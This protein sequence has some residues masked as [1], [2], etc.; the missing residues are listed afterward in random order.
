[1]Q[2]YL[3]VAISIVLFF[4]CSLP[5]ANKI[6]ADVLSKEKM[7]ALL[8]DIHLAE[9]VIATTPTQADS[10]TRRALGY[11]EIIYKKHQV[12]ETQ[13][14]QSYDFYTKHPVLLDSVYSR[15]IEKLSVQETILRK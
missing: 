12:T 3:F 8:Y 4:S 13:F 5:D 14:K 6:P 11:Y 2:K 7:E 10:N 15:V 9:G 1:M